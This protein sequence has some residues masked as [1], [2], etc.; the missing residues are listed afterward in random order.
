[1][2]IIAGTHKGRKLASLPGRAARPTGGKVREA[3]FSICTKAVRDAVVLDLFAGTGALG[4]EAISRGAA[5]A[6]F[7]DS[8]RPGIEVIRKNIAAC[9]EGYRS[10][11][12]RADIRAGLHP[13][14]AT[15]LFYDLVFIDPPYNRRAIRRTLENLVKTKT[16]N[17]GATIVIEHGKNETNFTDIHGLEVVD[18]RKYGKTLVTFMKWLRTPAGG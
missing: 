7:I 14:A 18:R 15:G 16:L 5:K 10:I 12:I 3:I 4:L 9:G 17:P 2:R 6:V 8:D 13:L 11:V 1:M